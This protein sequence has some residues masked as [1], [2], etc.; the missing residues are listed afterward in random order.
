MDAEPCFTV[1]VSDDPM[2][3]DVRDWLNK[4]GYVLEML[5]AQKIAKRTNYF[6]QGFHYTDPITKQERESDLQGLLNFRDLDDHTHAVQFV[7]ECKNSTA[8]WVFF[9][10]ETDPNGTWHARH[11]LDW[12][13]CS[14]CVAL[15]EDYSD[16]LR[17]T[18]IAYAVSEKRTRGDKDLAYEAA[19]QVTSALVAEYA[20]LHDD[21]DGHPDVNVTTHIG[22]PTSMA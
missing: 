14:L 17:R 3:T 20:P 6:W 16:L 22:V 12:D 10:G 7:I 5:V 13:R 9:M 4:G 15:L 11:Y 2:L 18:P 21:N 8:P 1:R 19:Q